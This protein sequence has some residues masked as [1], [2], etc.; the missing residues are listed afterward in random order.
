MLQAVA[1]AGRSPG[2]SLRFLP[3]SLGLTLCQES[4]PIAL[5]PVTAMWSL[6]KRELDPHHTVILLAFASATRALKAGKSCPAFSIMP[7]SH[8]NAL[9][10]L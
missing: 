7:C 4:E 2:T 6:K 8:Y 1:I 5:D 3:T 9:L 10:S